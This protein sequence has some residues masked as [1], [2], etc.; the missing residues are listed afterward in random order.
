MADG[1]FQ[2]G[3]EHGRGIG[4]IERWGLA[5]FTAAPGEQVESFADDEFAAVDVQLPAGVRGGEDGFVDLAAL[6]VN[7][8]EG[9]FADGWQGAAAWS[10]D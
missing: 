1:F 4:R 8:A 6:I 5:D 9:K 3:G 7:N 2:F 10:E